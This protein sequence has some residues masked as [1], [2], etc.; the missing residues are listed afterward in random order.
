MK[1]V[2]TVANRKAVFGIMAFLAC[3]A[4]ILWS[5][6]TYIRPG[7]QC[8]EDSVKLTRRTHDVLVKYYPS[9]MR[10]PHNPVPEPEFLRDKN[11]ELTDTWGIVI[12]TDEEIDQDT[13]PSEDRIPDSL[14]GVPV[15]ILTKEIGDK[16]RPWYPGWR[17]DSLSHPHLW[18]SHDVRGKNLDLLRQYPFFSGETLLV[19]YLSKDTGDSEPIFGIEVHVTEVVY[20]STLSPENR[21]PAC[22]DDVPVEIILEPS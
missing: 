5:I 10:L 6:D 11:G 22:L 9:I 12:L 17:P 2:V 8:G 15:Q 20:P 21:I 18:L 3:A 13:L 14:E 4:V 16:K 19:T 7:Y 1:G